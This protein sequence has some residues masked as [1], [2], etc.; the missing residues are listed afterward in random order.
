MP[1]EIGVAKLTGVDV[2]F[3]AVEFVGGVIAGG[4]I[5]HHGA[6][7]HAQD[8]AAQTHHLHRDILDHKVGDFSVHLLV[9]L[10]VMHR[11]FGATTYGDSFEP[12]TAHD[13]AHAGAGRRPTMIIHHPGIKHQIFTGRADAGHP[14]PAFL[15]LRPHSVLGLEHIHAPQVAGIVQAGLLLL[16]ATP[17]HTGCAACPV[18]M[19]PS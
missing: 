15:H 6:K 5:A 7:I 11:D 12:F 4:H 1:L 19:M 10:F 3:D 2:V 17:S 13:S 18:M 16:L 9:E 8:R 14:C